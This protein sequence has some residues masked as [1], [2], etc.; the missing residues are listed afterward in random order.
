MPDT[1]EFQPNEPGEGRDDRG[2]GLIGRRLGPYEILEEVGR[3]GMSVVYR[4]RD[5]R[6]DREVAI[7]VLHPFLADRED[8]RRR[9]EREARAVARLHHP[10]IL[11]IYD[12]S[13]EETEQSYIVTELV[14]GETLREFAERVTID[15]PELSALIGIKVCAALERAHQLGIVHRDV[16]PENVMLDQSGAVKLMDFGIAHMRDA[17]S[18]T[19]TGTLLGSPA[20]MAPEAIDGEAIDERADQFS[21]GTILYWLATAKLPFTGKNPHALLKK[22]SDGRYTPPQ[23]VN[24]KISD[25]LADVICRV[26]QGD[27][28][29][30]YPTIG[31][32]RDALNE[33]IQEGELVNSDE[34]L[35]RYYL[36]PQAT[37]A[38]LTQ[39]VVESFSR[40]AK[41]LQRQGETAQALSA[42][43]RVLAL[44]P[45]NA[46]ARE[47]LE[48]LTRRIRFASLRRRLG[49]WAAA[50][51]LA[52]ALL[53]VVG[54]LALRPAEVV[55]LDPTLTG[56]PPSIG[57]GRLSSAA[58][59][60]A[61]GG[62]SLSSE[63]A[64]SPAGEQSAAA[65][66]GEGQDRALDPRSFRK[67]GTPRASPLKKRRGAS[68]GERAGAVGPQRTVTFRVDPWAHIYVDDALIIENAK[69]ASP[70]LSPGRHRIRFENQYAA[71]IEKEI[72]VP[73]E[74]LVPTLS[75]KL[76]QM[77]PAYLTV[78]ATPAGAEVKVAGTYKGPAARSLGSPMVIAMPDRRH[79]ARFVVVLSHDGYQPMSLT[80]KFIAGERTTIKA[81]LRPL[82]VDQPADA[83]AMP[84]DAAPVTP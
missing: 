3:G 29:R 67:Y 68:D 37:R 53:G 54:W 44:D 12:F 43:S 14:R 69:I 83:Q 13:D 34:I 40:R 70:K 46:S 77:R 66:V 81:T 73:A 57:G 48:A 6:L 60:K 63:A 38:V 11:E 79:E 49:R 84:D 20:H 15:P 7:K 62:G 23:R 16:K 24:P 56:E 31:D 55:Q 4:G 17:S 8:A 36:E 39:T 51:T 71:P 80:E 33:V 50:V 47:E 72:E 22:I 19:L 58:V 35:R 26:L 78:K 64:L 2:S 25:R 28:G 74:G 32:L 30:R 61:P 41:D 27:P 45:D 65:A 52:A 59:V 21:L 82:P 10:N 75:V 1:V 42:M 18:L 76:V 9:F 5:T